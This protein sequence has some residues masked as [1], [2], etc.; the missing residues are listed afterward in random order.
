MK[1]PDASL[2]SPE[3]TL[4]GRAKATR[5]LVQNLELI[6]SASLEAVFGGEI[7]AWRS[8]ELKLLMSYRALFAV[9]KSVTLLCSPLALFAALVVCMIQG[10]CA[11]FAFSLLFNAIFQEIPLNA[12]L[13]FGSMVVLK[14]LDNP[15]VQAVEVASSLVEA[16]VSLARMQSFCRDAPDVRPL[17]PPADGALLVLKDACFSWSSRPTRESERGSGENDDDDDVALLDDGGSGALEGEDE[18]CLRGVTLSV[19]AGEFVWVAGR[20]REK[21]KWFFD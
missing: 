20:V 8:R 18:C 13:I 1:E 19:R 15:L 12:G 16:R 17:P 14:Q 21:E 10:W 5:Y 2:F 11:S 9:F 4:T 7:E 3:I 6:K